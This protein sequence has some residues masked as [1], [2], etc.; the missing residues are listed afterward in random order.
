MAIDYEAMIGD[1]NCVQCRRPL[2]PV[3]KRIRVDMGVIDV[4]RTS[5]L[6]G[7]QMMLG[8]NAALAEVFNPEP[9]PLVRFTGD[10]PLAPATLLCVHVECYAKG[11]DPALLEEQVRAGRAAAAAKEA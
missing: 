11:I 2:G 6:H 9:G 1:G 8:G 4:R 3:F 7:L 5:R 10:E